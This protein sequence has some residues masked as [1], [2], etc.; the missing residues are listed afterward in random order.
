MTANYLLISQIILK[1]IGG[2]KALLPTKKKSAKFK[3]KLYI[4]ETQLWREM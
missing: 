1:L 3:G 4:G 2:I